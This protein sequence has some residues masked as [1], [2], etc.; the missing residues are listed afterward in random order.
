MISRTSN[1]TVA[2]GPNPEPTAETG[3]ATEVT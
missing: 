3:A 2:L 1:E